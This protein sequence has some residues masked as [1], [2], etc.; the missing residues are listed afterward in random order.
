MSAGWNDGGG[1]EEMTDGGGIRKHMSQAVFSSCQKYYC[2]VCG[3][4]IISY[5]IKGHYLNR[6]DWDKL[7]KL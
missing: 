5:D 3:V 2:D 1:E 7:D 6:T 4:A